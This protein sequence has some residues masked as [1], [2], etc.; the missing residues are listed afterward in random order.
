M[1]FV[2]GP[3]HRLQGRLLV[4]PPR[5]TSRRTL[6]TRCN[7]TS[8]FTVPRPISYYDEEMNELEG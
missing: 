2:Q 7:L 8:P 1:C 6:H 3:A 5:G 4:Q